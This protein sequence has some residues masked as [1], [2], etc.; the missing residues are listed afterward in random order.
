RRFG[1]KVAALLAEPPADAWNALRALAD[2]GDK[3]AAL[4]AMQLNQDC[5]ALTRLAATRD[6]LRATWLDHYDATALP[7]DWLRM[8]HAIDDAQLARRTAFIASCAKI[9]GVRDF[10]LSLLDRFVQPDDPQ[11]QLDYVLAEEDDATAIPD[12]RRLAS[13]MD[14]DV[15][16]RALGE[17]LIQSR[18]PRDRDEGRALL[19]RLANSAHGASPEW[20]NAIG[21]LAN[22][23][24]N[25]CGSFPR[26]PAAAQAWLE[27]AA[28][29]GFAWALNTQ[30]GDLQASGNTSTAWAWAS[31]RFDLA[32][33]SCT[34]SDAPELFALVEAAETAY[35]IG[36]LLNATDQARGNA[37]LARIHATWWAQATAALD[38][39]L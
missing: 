16:R 34:Q 3:N 11:T 32:R 18:D 23:L 8:A 5:D 2:A 13:E 36:A 1:A 14:S 31:Y 37:E 22:C 7:S 26:D 39:D 25:G 4:A 20:R 12:L 30:I 15:A 6:G 9:G 19:E 21:F 28:G 24:R 27:R 29:L 10:A 35:R 33:A 38:C 17:R